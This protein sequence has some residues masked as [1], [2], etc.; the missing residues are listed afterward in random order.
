M[1][2]PYQIESPALISFGGGRTSGY[3]LSQ[4]LDAKP[5]SFRWQV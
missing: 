5:C 3:M 2:N 4:I 1:T